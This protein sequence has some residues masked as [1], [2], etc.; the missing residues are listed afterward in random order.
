MTKSG[1]A[2]AGGRKKIRVALHK[3]W[4]AKRRERDLTRR[5]RDDAESTESVEQVE[6]VRAKGS[7]SRKRTIR[8]SADGGLAIDP[9]QCQRGR[10][11][12]VHGLYCSVVTED[13]QVHRCTIRRLL[14]SLATDERGVVAT[15]DWVWFL[16]APQGE[17]RI[18]RVE[19]RGRSLTRAYR[20]REQVIA[21]NVDQ[22]LIVGS[23]VE[24]PLKPNLLDRYLLAAERSG[25]GPILCL[26]KID[27]IDPEDVRPV[28]ELYRQLGY[29]VVVTSA[30]TG[31]GIDSLRAVLAGRETVIVGQSGVGKSSLLNALEPTLNLKVARVSERSGKGRHTT[32]TARLIRFAE[33]GTV[34]DT[35]GVRQFESWDLPPA[36]VARYFREFEAFA[37]RCHFPGCRHSHE[38]GCAV[39]EA[40]D[41]DQI[42][43]GRY[44]SYLRLLGAPPARL[45]LDEELARPTAETNDAESEP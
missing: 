7:A 34:V 37:D 40:V 14:K 33:G 24:P 44:H 9:S 4:Q 16:P 11:L 15:G 28:V 38:T 39:K 5:Y 41:A 45:E 10:I 29:A 13:G 36:E 2:A 8:A 17:G 12:A 19:P 25:M 6:R 27:R 26:N 42:S 43:A 20:G 22:L 35:P 32:T 23:I 18:E 21:A 30:T 3:N 31:Q 1:D